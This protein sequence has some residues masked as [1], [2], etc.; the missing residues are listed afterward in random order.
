MH[1]FMKRFVALALCSFLTGCGDSEPGPEP[2]SGS[3]AAE[4]SGDSVAAVAV[5]DGVALCVFEGSG[6]EYK[7]GKVVGDQVTLFATF[8][9]V[10]ISLKDL[11]KAVAG[12]EGEGADDWRKEQRALGNALLAQQLPGIWIVE[13]VMMDGK[14][15]AVH[16]DDPNY[17]VIRADKTFRL[18]KKGRKPEGTWKLDA[19]GQLAMDSTNDESKTA[20]IKRQSGDKLELTIDD[21]GI[22]VLLR[23]GRSGLTEEPKAIDEQ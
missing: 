20:K 23:Y 3:P 13:N 2:D 8:G 18:I 5:R 12:I 7:V 1:F 17:L 4:L 6:R 16:A 19:E 10:T 9:G 11:E 22:V 21:K 15:E 14:A